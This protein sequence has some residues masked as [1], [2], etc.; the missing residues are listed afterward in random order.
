MDDLYQESPWTPFLYIMDRIEWLWHDNTGEAFVLL[1]VLLWYFF[2]GSRLDLLINALLIIFWSSDKFLHLLRG[3]I[4][5]YSVPTLAGLSLVYCVFLAYHSGRKRAWPGPGQPFLI[6]GRTTHSRRYPKKH[7]FSYSYLTVGVPVGFRGNVKGMLEVEEQQ[8][9]SLL[10]SFA[11]LLSSG[12]YTVHASDYLER[13]HGKLGLR[14]KL[15]N[16][17]RSQVRLL[18]NW[19]ISVC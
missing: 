13:G 17:L 4:D 16:Y 15:D 6:P 2:M 14:G 19:W 8:S 7:S 5:L 3:Y 12:W 18:P 11:K 10:R 1:S 9:T